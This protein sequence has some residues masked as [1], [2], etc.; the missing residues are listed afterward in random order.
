MTG[1]MRAS[2]IWSRSWAIVS[3]PLLI[4]YLYQVIDSITTP[5]PGI[6]VPGAHQFRELA[7]SVGDGGFR[8]VLGLG[9]DAQHADLRDRHLGRPSWRCR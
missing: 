6:L 8:P 7:L 3:L 4:M 2:G 9:G 1:T 5:N